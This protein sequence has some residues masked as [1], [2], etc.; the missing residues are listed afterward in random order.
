M[1]GRTQGGVDG[2]ERPPS[3][4]K[5]RSP[6]HLIVLLFVEFT[7]YTHAYKYESVH[8]IRTFSNDD[9]IHNFALHHERSPF[10]K[11][12][13]PPPPPPSRRLR[14]PMECHLFRFK[15]CRCKQLYHLF[16]I[17]I[18]VHTVKIT[19]SGY[20]LTCTGGIVGDTS[21]TP[22]VTWNNS[23]GV[24]SSGNGITVSNGIVTFN[25]L[26]THL[27]EASTSASLH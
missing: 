23:N 12:R 10:I 21:L 4:P 22:V 3:L 19:T 26:H 17:I 1:H 16:H 25:P 13:P 11:F 5:T 9:I 20:T 8:A 6:S 27:L 14:T 2:F 18:S 7:T 15:H 24:I